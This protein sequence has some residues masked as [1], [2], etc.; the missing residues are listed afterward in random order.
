MV[1]YDIVPTGVGDLLIVAEEDGLT[2]VLFDGHPDLSWQRDS[3]PGSILSTVR[4]QIESYFAG[5]RTT[6]DV[7]LAPRGT[8][9]QQRVWNELRAIPYGTTITYGELARRVGDVKAS[10]A[11][12]AAN[13]RNPI[14]IIVPCHRVVGTNGSLTGFGGG[15]A[16]KLW[17]LRHEGTGDGLF[18]PTG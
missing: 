12:G 9:F 18:E 3:S 8:P 6:F 17:L 1:T 4:A 16:R 14:P 13:G 11:V 2:E 5:T 7:P 10:R 15:M